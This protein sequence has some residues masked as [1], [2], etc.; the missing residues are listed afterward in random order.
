ML[1]ELTDYVSNTMNMSFLF[2]KKKKKFQTK[3]VC[4]FEL[5][6]LQTNKTRE[7]KKEG[8][9]KTTQ[10]YATNMHTP[11]HTITQAHTIRCLILIKICVVFFYYYFHY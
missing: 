10:S 4:I 8:I 1:C 7:K 6:F 9:I 5:C 3:Y 11:T 2:L